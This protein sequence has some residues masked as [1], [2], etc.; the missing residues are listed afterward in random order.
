MASG[1]VA[2]SSCLE[3]WSIDT[4]KLYLLRLRTDSI[5]RSFQS[6]WPRLYIEMARNSNTTSFPDTHSKVYSTR[7]PS[8]SGQSLKGRPDDASVAIV[9]ARGGLLCL[10]SNSYRR[11]RHCGRF[12]TAVDHY[13][14]ARNRSPR[15]AWLPARDTTYR[16]AKFLYQI[17]GEGAQG[18]KSFQSRYFADN[19]YLRHCNQDSREREH[20][21]R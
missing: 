14:A 4:Y 7:W 20:S 15:L 9:S 3:S 2:R 21:R 17:P 10:C 1:R 13:G 16:N 6:I 12:P 5:V 8:F 19:L 18:F 11:R